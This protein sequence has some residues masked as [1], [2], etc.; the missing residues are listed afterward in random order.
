MTTAQ[1]E[2]ATHTGFDFPFGHLA[3]KIVNKIIKKLIDK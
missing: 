3:L 1:Q 2:Q